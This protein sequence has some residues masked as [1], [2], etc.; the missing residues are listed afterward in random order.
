MMKES[1]RKPEKHILKT[2][3][4]FLGFV[5]TTAFPA[6]AITIIVV[7]LKWIVS[8]VLLPILLLFYVDK[9]Y[10]EVVYFFKMYID[11]IFFQEN[12]IL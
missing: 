1:N 6:Q 9:I 8:V 7:A 3:I 12:K 2:G 10:S 5:V 11:D 4:V